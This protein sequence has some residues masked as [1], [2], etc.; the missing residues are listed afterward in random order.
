MATTQSTWNKRKPNSN[1]FLVKF[2]L[3]LYKVCWLFFSFL[4]V[5]R[6]HSMYYLFDDV[7]KKKIAFAAVVFMHFVFSFSRILCHQKL[8]TKKRGKKNKNQRQNAA[9]ERQTFWNGLNKM[10]KKKHS[11]VCYGNWFGVTNQ[12]HFVREFLCKVL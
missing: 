4:L 5:A 3:C 8:R 10:K 2:L 11:Q 1:T 6:R 12:S 7:N 9:A